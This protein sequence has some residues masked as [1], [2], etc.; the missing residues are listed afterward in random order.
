MTQPAS[1][2]HE[3]VETARVVAFGLA[4]A[5]TW[6]SVAYQP[7]TIPSASMEP[8]LIEGDYLVVS[9]WAYGWSGASLPMNPPLGEDRLF[10]RH[11]ARGDVVVFRHPLRPDEPWIKRVIGLPG[12]RV[13]VRA[14]RVFVNGLP[15]AQ[16]SLGPG[17][18]ASDPGRPV[19]RLRETAPDGARRW[20]IHDFGPGAPG[21]DTPVIAV[22]EGSYLVLGDN[23]D[24]S[25]D[26]RWSSEVGVGFLPARNLIGR[27]EV[28]VAS[29]KPGASLWKPWTWLN[30]QGRWFMSIR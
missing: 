2:R 20:T 7:F 22:P 3:L 30:L 1:L 25:L 13:Q 15:F 17:R 12:D 4:L 5:V 16:T 27:A 26:G 11:P 28:V 23:R 21:D 6:T 19:T 18:S 9:K 8:G 14:G 29:W 24:N 10:G